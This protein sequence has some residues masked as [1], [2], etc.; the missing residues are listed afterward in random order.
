MAG[1]IVIGRNYGKLQVVEACESPESI[2]IPCPGAVNFGDYCIT[3]R[4]ATT[5]M[6]TKYRFTASPVG[7]LYVRSRRAE[8]RISFAFGTKSL[9]K[10]FID[11]K[12]P[13]SQRDYIP[14]IADDLGLLGVAGFGG[15]MSRSTDL[16]NLIEISIETII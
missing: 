10:L 6:N 13:A 15:D 3:A 8:D 5:P 12:I 2:P 11:Q 14:V 4:K 16:N 1:G 7:E 9:K